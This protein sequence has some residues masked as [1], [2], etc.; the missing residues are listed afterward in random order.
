MNTTNT[1]S[2]THIFSTPV[3]ENKK[4][5][6][7]EESSTSDSAKFEDDMKKA[8]SNTHHNTASNKTDSPDK[9]ANKE[10]IDTDSRSTPPTDNTETTVLS[11]ADEEAVAGEILVETVDPTLLVNAPNTTIV[12][13][14]VSSPLL[15]VGLADTIKHSLTL[16]DTVTNEEPTALS[17]VVDTGAIAI[18]ST[19]KPEI[20]AAPT[21]PSADQ[22]SALPIAGAL[23]STTKS[24]VLADHRLSQQFNEALAVETDKPET[25]LFA[26]KTKMASAEAPL[27]N[28]TAPLNTSFTSPR[29]GEAVTEKVMWMSARGLKEATIQLDPPELGQMTIKI[30]VQQDQAQVSFTVQ[31]ASV[32]EALDSNALRLREMFAEDGLNLADVDVSDQSQSQEEE[33]AQRSRFNQQGDDENMDD[34]DTDT[35]P[36]YQ[37]YSLIDSY[38]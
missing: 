12:D 28:H 31:N 21:I 32:R 30:G 23:L 4:S 14:T 19:I 2:L 18:N 24:S 9:A 6:I 8:S 16:D 33:A 5:H 15:S 7:A 13:E 10:N 37:R 38:V 11:A 22:L 35:Q 17:P 1:T 36:V 27:P 25:T 3:V 20:T 29:W 26:P 34:A